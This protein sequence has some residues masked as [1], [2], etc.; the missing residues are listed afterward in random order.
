MVSPN[1]VAI[2]P[3]SKEAKALRGT[4]LL[5]LKAIPTVTR[6]MPVSISF[7]TL[8]L[9]TS[10][11]CLAGFPSPPLLLL[12]T[13]I[14]PALML[15][16]ASFLNCFV[17]IFESP[18]LPSTT[19]Y[20]SSFI[21]NWSHQSPSNISASFGLVSSV[22]FGAKDFSI[23]FTIDST[24]SWVRWSAVF[25]FCVPSIARRRPLSRSFC[26]EAPFVGGLKLGSRLGR[27]K[28]NPPWQLSA[29]TTTNMCSRP[30]IVIKAGKAAKQ[31]RV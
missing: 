20:V 5:G 16:C 22:S 10:K 21:V 27:L 30:I 14:P 6:P 12:S 1:F 31:N 2:V 11:D 13:L 23:S 4:L 25:P 28:A 9:A 24:P 3:V 26:N 7:T 29:A 19:E 8:P 17:V 15:P 18:S